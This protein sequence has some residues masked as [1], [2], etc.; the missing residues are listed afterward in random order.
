[1]TFPI[2]DPSGPDAARISQLGWLL[3]VL[4]TVIYVA[5]LIATAWALWR[6]RTPADDSPRTAARATAT[7]T[8]ATA[9]TAL[10]LVGLTFASMYFGRVV[11]MPSAPD[12]ILV[13]VIGHQWWW[14]FQYHDISPS[15]L[16]TTANELH[17]PVGVPVTLR[18][19]SRDVIHS[20]WVPQLQG[21]RDV[22][23]GKVS[24]ITLTADEP[25]RFD[26]RCAEFCGAQHA[27]MAFTV[28]AE[29]RPAFERWVQGHRQ[30][31]REPATSDETRGREVFLGS[32]CLLCHTIRGTNAGGRVGPDLTHLASRPHIAA[33]V[34][35]NT[36]EDLARWIRD[37]QAIKPGARMPP[38]PVAGDDLRALVTYLR[39][40]Q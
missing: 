19:Q 32:T 36:P 31:A 22:I 11:A 12:T 3:I 29:R 15:G 40:L 26:G 13:D 33:G 25:G 20:F 18:T 4:S 10:I 1:M 30:A 37:P 2:F 21:K 28:V 23:P 34:L 7:V 16:V 39:S 5:V 9:A 8:T 17:I 14:E 27:R 24:T 6:R 38:Q 35:P